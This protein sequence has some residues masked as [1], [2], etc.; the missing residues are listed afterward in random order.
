MSVE[1]VIL[2]VL[3]ATWGCMSYVAWRHAARRGL[4]G[5]MVNSCAVLCHV[6]LF[7]MSATAQA[8]TQRTRSVERATAE[9]VSST[10]AS[11]VRP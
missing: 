1:A 2:R 4:Y 9:D 5:P 7:F 3:I 6:A 11:S 10:E 8:S